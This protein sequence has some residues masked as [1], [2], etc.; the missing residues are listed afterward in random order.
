MP[1]GQS[2]TVLI[3]L[4]FGSAS[5][6]DPTIFPVFEANGP[7]E[8]GN[9]YLIATLNELIKI[10]EMSKSGCDYRQLLKGMKAQY[11]E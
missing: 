8:K 6:Y 5:N 4:D 7:L 3:P 1:P 2:K 11:D 9:M 10:R